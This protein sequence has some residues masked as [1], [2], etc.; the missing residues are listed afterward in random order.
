M[1]QLGQLLEARRRSKKDPLDSAEPLTH[2]AHLSS[3]HIVGGRKGAAHA[4]DMINTL[5]NSIAAGEI[6]PGISRKMD[7]SPSVQITSDSASTKSFANKVPKIAKTP[8]HVAQFYGHSDKLARTMD[9]VLTHGTK[10]V[11]KGM[12]V[13]ADV[14][15]LG[16][17][18]VSFRGNDVSYGMNTL[19][20]SHKADSDHGKQAKQ[21][22]LGLA[23]HTVYD[24]GKPRPITPQEVQ[25]LQTGGKKH[26]VHVISPIIDGKPSYHA[27]EKIAVG[28]LV[29]AYNS[30][31][32]KMDPEGYSTLSRHKQHLEPYINSKV[33]TNDVPDSKDYGNWLKERGQKAADGVKLLKTKKSKIDK[34]KELA[35]DAKQNA[36]HID[37]GLMMFQTA[38]RLSKHFSNV[39]NRD[40][41]I[42]THFHDGT[43]TDHEG[44]QFSH[45]GKAP[46]KL[47][48]RYEFS[49]QN[50]LR[51]R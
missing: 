51:T 3:L 47:V 32:A 45:K 21:S 25:M 42:D 24:K 22:E 49:R 37:N 6:P 20:Y 9:K 36:D 31:H 11:P 15:H 28:R 38:N 2:S 17:D 44:V 14:M 4:A 7:G 8:E 16:K 5:S 1:N 10:I 39:L 30:L 48:D 23:P 43:K 40:S 18:N 46:V 27:S 50:K 29:D 26:G 34:Y 35:D 19:R 12:V 13:Q 41:G 33:W